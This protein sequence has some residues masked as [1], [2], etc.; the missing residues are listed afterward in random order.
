MKASQLSVAP[1]MVMLCLKNVHCRPKEFFLR[2]LHVDHLF[3]EPQRVKSNQSEV[4]SNMK[5]VAGFRQAWVT[6]TGDALLKSLSTRTTAKKSCR[7]RALA[8]IHGIPHPIQLSS[9]VL[10]TNAGKAK[11]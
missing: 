9:L 7:Y 3:H 2:R 5:G 8:V 6:L 10:E 11:T 1:D 4:K